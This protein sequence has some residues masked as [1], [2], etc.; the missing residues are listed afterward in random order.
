MSLFLSKAGQAEIIRSAQKD[1]QFIDDVHL[2]LSELFR[3]YSHNLWLKFDSHLRTF[4]QIFYYSYHALLGIQT[5]GEEYTGVVQ[6]DQN[7][8]GLPNRLV[9]TKKN[10]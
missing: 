2:T 4:V 3:R 10:H 1:T 5:V 9:R 8:R 7:Y 6:I